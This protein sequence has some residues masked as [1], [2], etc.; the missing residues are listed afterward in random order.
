MKALILSALL[1]VPGAVLAA[2]DKP[3]ATPDQIKMVE[4]FVKAPASD[5]PAGHIDEFLAI[6]P[7]SLP[8]K[9]QQ[10][11]KAK[12]L[13]LYT[14]KQLSAG[15]KK[16]VFRMPQADCDIPR[17]AKSNDLKA[18]G[19]AGYA[20]ITDDEENCVVKI[21][22]CTER[23]MMCEF[24][25]QIVIETVGKKKQ[26]VRHLLLHQNDPLQ[27]IVAE[28]RAGVGGQTNFFGALKPS[29]SH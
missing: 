28:C 13:E 5:L 19:M 2:D 9:L 8:K 27:A 22:H 6:E 14:L 29:C 17:D 21:S 3:A 12:R 20:E 1:A 7:D 24:T 26:R 11:F 25:L 16:G 23:D 4:F 15:K 10:P 18:L